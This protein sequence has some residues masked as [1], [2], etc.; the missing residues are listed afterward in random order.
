[1]CA[2]KDNQKRWIRIFDRATSEIAYYQ[3]PRAPLYVNKYYEYQLRRGFQFLIGNIGVEGHDSILEIGSGTGR[4]AQELLRSGFAGT[5]CGIDFNPK[6]IRLSQNKNL[7]NC[8][9][10]TMD[11]GSLG[12]DSNVFDCAMSITALQHIPNLGWRD[13]VK[14][15]VRVVKP[16]GEIALIEDKRYPWV[17]EFSKRE[18]KLLLRRGQRYSFVRELPTS[19]FSVPRKLDRLLTALSYRFEPAFENFVPESFA[20]HVILAFRNH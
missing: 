1:M 11:G 2:R 12:F 13:A 20:N 7:P 15:M 8:H 19:L 14:E 17:E 18:C 4:W 6:A 16:S 10:L 5:Y 3:R 9:F